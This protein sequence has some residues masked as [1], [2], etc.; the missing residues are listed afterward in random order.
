MA[1]L[2]IDVGTGS[3]AVALA[4]AR[5][6]SDAQVLG[7][8]I[9]TR[10]VACARENAE[11]LGVRNARFMRGALLEPLTERY[12]GRVSTICSNVP[13]VAPGGRSDDPSPNDLPHAV[14][15]P[16]ADGLGHMRVIAET[17]RKWLSD[18]GRLVFQLSDWQWESFAEYLEGQGFE[19]IAPSERRPGQAIVGSAIWHERGSTE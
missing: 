9:S 2:M 18:G 16:D 8:D 10:A 17:A 1:P 5:R 15:G 6:R 12:S 4:F 19:P 7:F 14:F 13:Y 3:G 11:R